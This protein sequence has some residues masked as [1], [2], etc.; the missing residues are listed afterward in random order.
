[1]HICK[2]DTAVTQAHEQERSLQ[3]INQHLVEINVTSRYI[4]PKN[5]INQSPETIRASKLT[6]QKQKSRRNLKSTQELLIFLFEHSS[7]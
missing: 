7:S 3:D 6:K 4:Y 1:M 5:S 2:E